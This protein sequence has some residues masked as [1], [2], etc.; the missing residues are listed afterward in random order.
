MAQ[1]KARLAAKPR[2]P[3]RV[4]LPDGS[5]RDGVSWETT[6]LAIAEGISKGLAGSVVVARVSYTSR[7]G[8]VDEDGVNAANTGPEEEDAPGAAPNGSKPELWDLTRP[9]EGDCHL[10]L[11]KFEDKD[12]KAVFWHSSAHVLGE[13]LECGLGGKLCIG[14]PTE[15]GFYYDVYL[16][17]RSITEADYPSLVSKA[18]TV[19]KAKQPFERIVLTKAQALRLFE[20]NPFKVALISTK[21]PDGGYTTA[22]RCGPLIDLCRGPH[23]PTTAAIKA[24]DVVKHSAAY[25]L[26]SADND[27]LQRVYGVSFPDVKQMKAYKVMVE[28]ARKRDHRLLGAQQELF[29]FHELSPGSCFFLPHGARLYNKLQDFIR[30]Q[31]RRRG[32]SEVV[33]PNMYNIDLWRI[34]GEHTGSLLVVNAVQRAMMP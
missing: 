14:P 27:S 33:T 30:G 5:V 20:D 29:F 7:I 32:Y 18:E 9:L 12:G 25:W 16:G 23:V 4:T 31:Y 11:L 21:I 2:V 6:P 3:I 8:L 24:F 13:C 26:G 28:E 22:Y 17:A 19:A 1:Q 15:E 34:S 10:A